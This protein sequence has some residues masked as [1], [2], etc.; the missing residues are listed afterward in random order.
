MTGL[1]MGLTPKQLRNW[2][3]VAKLHGATDKYCWPALDS[4]ASC[5]R[6]ERLDYKD[7]ARMGSCLRNGE[8][9]CWCGKLTREIGGDER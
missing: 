2:H 4:M 1:T 6:E 5:E 9:R 3:R 7:A 8:S